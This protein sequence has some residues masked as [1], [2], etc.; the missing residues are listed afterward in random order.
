MV[1]LAIVLGMITYLDRVCISTLAPF[2]QRDLRLDDDQMSYVFSAF[3]LSYAAFGIPAA[4]WADQVGMRQAGGDRRVV[5]VVYDVDGGGREPG[6][7]DADSSALRGGRSR[8]LAVGRSDVLA[9]DS[10]SRGAD[11]CR[12]FSS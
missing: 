6:D 9:M 2:I 3:A 7:D 12:E 8:S 4:A 11:E 1:G 5:V 10:V